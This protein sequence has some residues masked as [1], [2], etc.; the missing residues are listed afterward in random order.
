M[1]V[2]TVIMGTASGGTNE[3]AASERR[4]VVPRSPSH[5]TTSRV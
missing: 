5:S 4:R 3:R 1:R 2:G